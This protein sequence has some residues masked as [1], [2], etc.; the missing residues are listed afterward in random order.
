MKAE[1]DS[2]IFII[3][4]LTV[5]KLKTQ[6]IHVE[7]FAYKAMANRFANVMSAVEEMLFVPVEKRL[8]RLLLKDEKAGTVYAT[9]ESLARKAG[10]AREV[11]SRTLSQLKEKGI[12][13]QKRGQIKI[14]DKNKLENLADF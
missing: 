6:N 2:E 5:E 10:T 11:V 13:E 3:P 9:Q 4:S 1:V 14:L 7:L 12:I 8:S